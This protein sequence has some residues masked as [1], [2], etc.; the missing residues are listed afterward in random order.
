MTNLDQTDDGFIQTF[1]CKQFWFQNPTDEMIDI[2]DIAHALSNLCRYGGHCDRFYSVA[3]HSVLLSRKVWYDLGSKQSLMA[4]LHDAGEAY[5]V[6]MPRP[7]KQE[8]SQYKELEN[9]IQGAIHK[10]FGLE[11]PIPDWMKVYDNRMLH[12]E[13][14]QTMKSGISWFSDSLEPLD[15]ELEYWN[16]EYAKTQ[17][18]NRFSVLTQ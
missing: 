10:K 15:I 3:E 8:L 9:K 6:D 17:F 16:P 7:I 2:E 1:M 11:F 14:L 5:L 4:L 13:R 12:T 18:L